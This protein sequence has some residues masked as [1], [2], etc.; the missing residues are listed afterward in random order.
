MFMSLS[1]L[2]R[3]L[4]RGK[5]IQEEL[6]KDIQ[7]WFNEWD[8]YDYDTEEVEFIVDIMCKQM[9]RDCFDFSGLLI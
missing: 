2:F 9:T 6:H 7:N 5:L 8:S 3:S 1:L 4:V